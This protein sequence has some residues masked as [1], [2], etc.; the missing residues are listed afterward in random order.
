MEKYSGT[1]SL[2]TSISRD[3]K[4]PA[5]IDPFFSSTVMLC[6]QL[7][8]GSKSVE[9]LVIW[10]LNN[11]NF[12]QFRFTYEKNLVRGIPGLNIPRL[13]TIICK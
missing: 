11:N 2:H 4:K 9:T 13:S 3:Q 8:I 5:E 1:S 6:L 7:N 10:S 12:L